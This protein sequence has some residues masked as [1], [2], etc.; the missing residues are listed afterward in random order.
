L[1]AVVILKSIMAREILEAFSDCLTVHEDAGG[2]FSIAVDLILIKV[3]L[4]TAWHRQ[5]FDFD[6]K[7]S[8][9]IRLKVEYEAMFCTDSTL[10]FRKINQR[11]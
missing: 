7:G 2:P 8:Q 11:S 5:E 1:L 9:R 3:K 4:Y 10:Q 6:N